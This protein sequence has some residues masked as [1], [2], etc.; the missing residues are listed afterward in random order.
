M[1]LAR[2]PKATREGACAPRKL[3]RRRFLPTNQR[4][5]LAACKSQDDS[6]RCSGLNGT[7]L[8]RLSV[9]TGD[10][11]KL[12]SV[13]CKF[14]GAHPSRVLVEA[15]RLDE[16]LAW[17][18]LQPS[19]SEIRKASRWP[20]VRAGGTPARETRALPRVP[21]PSA[22]CNTNQHR[23]KNALNLAPFGFVLTPAPDLQTCG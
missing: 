16:L 21:V 22:I 12:R 11:K 23:S 14:L 10:T 19:E 8:R 1:P 3:A 18:R 5:A 9:G 15:S 7:N 6:V 20:E 4:R 13:G 17:M 2:A